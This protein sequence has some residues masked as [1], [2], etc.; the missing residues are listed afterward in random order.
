MPIE[1]DSSPDRGR[2]AWIALGVAVI[3]SGVLAGWLALRA[4]L[5]RPSDRP[6]PRADQPAPHS[7]AG[8]V[9]LVLELPAPRFTGTPHNLK[10]ANL[11]KPRVGKRPDLLVPPGATNM[12]RSK[13]VTAS[14]SSPTLGELAQV[15]DGDKEGIEGSY[16]EIGPGRQ[17]F[18]VDLGEACRIHAIVVWHYHAQPRVYRDVIVQVASDPTFARNVT[19]VFNNDHDNSSLLGAGQDKEY[20]DGHEGLLVDA[21]GI[22]GRYVRLYGNG[23]TESDLN[24]C[25][26]I[27]VY[28]T[29]TGGEDR[30]K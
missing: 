5:H 3:A 29:R 26:E 2:R 18:Q 1:H 27:E 25:T 19:T 16:V 20:I 21:R 10:S 7:H 13:P 28:A 30:R 24:H 14:D 9:P 11:A 17:H 12:A 15:T 23:N 4:G 22:S 6:P 8:R